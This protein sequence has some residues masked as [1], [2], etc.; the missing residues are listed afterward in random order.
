LLK[1][2]SILFD[3]KLT[4]N[5]YK[6]NAYAEKIDIIQWITSLKDKST[7]QLLSKIKEQ[8]TKN[9]DWWTVI[10]EEERLSIEKGLDDLSNDKVTSHSEVRK[11]YEKWL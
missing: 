5:N 10:S 9:K 2:I 4:K 7:L 11:K 1:N 8:S 6:M 3:L